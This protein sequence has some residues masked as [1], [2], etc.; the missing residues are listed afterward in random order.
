M[1]TVL[2]VS[3][4]SQAVIKRPLETPHRCEDASDAY[5][6]VAAAATQVLLLKPHAAVAPATAGAAAI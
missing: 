4:R 3:G 2:C 5:S 6:V 1:K